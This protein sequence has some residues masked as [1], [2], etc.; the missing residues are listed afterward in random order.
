MPKSIQV[1]HQDTT[2]YIPKYQKID[3]LS[4]DGKTIYKNLERRYFHEGRVVHPSYLDDQ[5]NLLQIFSTIDQTLSI[6][7]VINN[8]DIRFRLEEFAR[9]LRIPCQGVYVFSTEWSISSL[10]NSIDPN[11]NYLPPVENPQ[12]IHDTIF[13]ERP[14]GT[15]HKVKKKQVVLD[16]FQ[17]VTSKVKL[18]FKN[19]ES[20]LNEML[21][22]SVIRS[23]V[24]VL[25]Y[26]M[27]LTRLFEHVRTT[28]PIAISDLRYLSDNV[29]VPLTEAKTHRIMIKGKRPHPQTPS[30]S[31]SEPSPTPIK[32]KKLTRWTITPL[33][34]LST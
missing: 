8:V 11:P 13:Y 31:S 28:H 18:D 21:M 12:T 4:D 23:N 26:G 20:I 5:P 30:K 16:P 10:S 25:P 24:M 9:I 2:F 29:M 15:T 7:L 34:L 17:M 14:L 32:N 6:A 27:L 33:I 22:K 19:W 1:D 3:G